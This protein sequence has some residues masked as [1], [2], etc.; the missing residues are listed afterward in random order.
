MVIDFSL[1]LLTHI[2]SSV[3]F[4]LSYI[5]LKTAIKYNFTMFYQ[6]HINIVCNKH[7]IVMRQ[8]L[9]ENTVDM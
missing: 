2:I 9:H 3:N 7:L 1:V 8:F 4:L 5:L 6:F